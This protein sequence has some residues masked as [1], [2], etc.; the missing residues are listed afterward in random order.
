[1]ASYLIINHGLLNLKVAAPVSFG[2][3]TQ[4]IAIRKDHTELAT[5]I[6]KA[7]ETIKPDEHMQIRQKWI[8]VRYEYGIQPT[9]I[10]KWALG[11]MV[12]VSLSILVFVTWNRQLSRKVKKRTA[13]LTNSESRF[14]SIFE[15]VA[16]G[17]AH[18]SLE[19]R[20][21]RINQRFC[22]IMG[23][24]HDEIIKLTVQDITHPNERDDE[25]E[26]KRQLMVGGGNKSYGMENKYITREGGIVW[27]NLTVSLVR[28][29]AGKP[30]YFLSVI[31]DITKRKEFQEERD[32]ILNLSR[33]LICIARMDGYFKYVNPAWKLVLGYTREELLARPFLDFI[34]PDDHTK[35]ILE[36]ESLTAGRQSINFENRYI[37]KDGNIHHI[38]WIGI[39]I[40]DK[41]LIYCIGRDITEQKKAM[42]ELR[43]NRDY[44]KALTDSMPDVVFS[45]RMPERTIEWSNDTFKVLGYDRE[46]YIGKTTEFLYPSKEDFLAFGDKTARAIE[47]GKRVFHTE[48]NLRRKSG[49]LFPVEIT[50]SISKREGELVSITSVVKDVTERKQNEHQLQ[51]YQQRLKALAYQLTLAEERERR[52]I[53]SELHDH[54]GH[55]LILARMQLKKIQESK[56]AIQRNLLINDLSK[57]LLKTIQDT[58]SLTFKLS[59]LMMNEVGLTVS[60][61]E[62]MQEY[63][64]N[65]YNLEIEFIDDSHKKPMDQDTQAILFRNVRELLINVVKHAKAKKVCVHM[66]DLSEMLK[67]TVID[68]GIG[69]DPNGERLNK[70]SY[71]KCFGLFSIRERMSDL[72]GSL[73]IISAPGKGS[74]VILSTPLATRLG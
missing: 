50:S 59:S 68:D 35:N 36:I 12:V 64:K 70:R 20:F 14:R 54:I 62:W 38:S 49:D 9:N 6:R 42:E 25:L 7:I 2:P 4:S 60:L 66:E 17:I 26:Y 51:Q 65:Q 21:I 10:F 40:V 22:D 47:E 24:T 61:S 3:H 41:K 67:I 19:G 18:V 45:V 53:A 71:N 37:C 69:F 15:Q 44:L 48:Q 29:N 1:V 39:P 43:Q 32:R 74:K 16:V 58:K 11:I 52:H 30:A 13:E 5:A 46:E 23:Y 56:S 57:I 28:D 63:I 72:G 34:H 8:A 55:S 33:D 27:V 73:E 31:E